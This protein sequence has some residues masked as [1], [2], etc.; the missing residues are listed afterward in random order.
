MA[1]L[2]LPPCSAAAHV[3]CLG[4]MQVQLRSCLS[5]W[6]TD[7]LAPVHATDLLPVLRCQRQQQQ[8]VC[9]HWALI[10][11]T[12]ASTGS[13]GGISS[14]DGDGTADGFN[15]LGGTNSTAVGSDA[16]IGSAVSG[17]DAP[18]TDPTTGAGANATAPDGTVLGDAGNELIATSVT[19]VY[20]TDGVSPKG[21]FSRLPLGPPL[22]LLITSAAEAD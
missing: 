19:K 17:S 12:I 10:S 7:R 5:A 1:T 18:A 15:P 22:G 11:D 9:S 4:A 3:L 16:T 14:G 6:A 2:P 20:S 8:Q 13:N 21:G